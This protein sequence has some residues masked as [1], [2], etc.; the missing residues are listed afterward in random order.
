MAAYVWLVQCRSVKY[1]LDGVGIENRGYES[2]VANGAY[3]CCRGRREY[4]DA[5]GFEAQGGQG[6]HESGAEMASRT[7]DEDI[8]W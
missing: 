3:D 2:A 1:V 5:Q 4:V 6:E 8:V 7:G